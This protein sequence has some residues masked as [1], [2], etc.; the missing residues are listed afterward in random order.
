MSF[1]LFVFLFFHTTQI[2]L[3]VKTA[4]PPISSPKLR[5]TTHG[6]EAL[7]C[8]PCAWCE[9]YLTNLV[10]VQRLSPNYLSGE[11]FIAQVPS[12]AKSFS[13]KTALPDKPAARKRVR[14]A[15]NYIHNFLYKERNLPGEATKKDCGVAG[16]VFQLT[17]I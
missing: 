5:R 13:R 1:S 8:C 11:Q 16:Y 6:G 2:I 3:S 4:Q 15:D 10:T 17:L 7:Q 12:G 9:Y 14:R